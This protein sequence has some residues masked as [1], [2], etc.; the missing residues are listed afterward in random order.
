M[1]RIWCCY[2]DCAVRRP[3]P[4]RA[5]AVVAVAA[6]ALGAFAGSSGMAA[7]ASVLTATLVQPALPGPAIGQGAQS[8]QGTQSAQNAR[9]AQGAW[10]AVPMNRVVLPDMFAVAAR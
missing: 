3:M 6:I 2:G 4:R 7:R 8:A 1:C 10:A 9:A 5:S